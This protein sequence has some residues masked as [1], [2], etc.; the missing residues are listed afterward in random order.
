MHRDEESEGG[1]AWKTLLSIALAAVT[2]V[3]ASRWFR[4]RDSQDAPRKRPV[5]CSIRSHA[6]LKLVIHHAPPRRLSVH[7]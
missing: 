7:C 6:A 2:M 3:A 4:D 5:R 1:G